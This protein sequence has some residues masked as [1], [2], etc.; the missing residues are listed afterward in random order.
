MTYQL[1]LFNTLSRQVEEFKPLSPGMV[2][3]YCCGPTVYDYQHIG[4]FKTFLIEDLLI[5]TLKLAG[6]Q[7]KFIM[8][9][10]DVGHLAS[11]ADEGED[12]MLIAARREKKKSM[13]IAQYYTDKFLEDWDKLNITRPETFCKA[14]DH[15]AEMIAMIKTLEEKG[16]AYLADGNVYFD[17]MRFK[18][19]GQLALLDL[20]KLQA[21]ARV[22]VDQNKRSPF[23][24]VLWFTKSKFENHELLWDSPWGKGYPGWHIECSAMASKYLGENID[25]HCGGVDHIPVH[26][27]NEIAQAEAAFG[28]KWVNFWVHSE[29]ILINSEKMAKSKGNFLKLDDLTAQG[30]EPAVYRTLILGTHYRKQLNFSKDSMDNA[31][32]VLQKLKAEVLKL[33]STDTPAEKLSDSAE[34]YATAFREAVFNDLNTP[35]ALAQV[36]GLLDDKDISSAEKLSLLYYFDQILGLKISDWQA[37][38]IDVPEAVKIL[39]EK[40]AAARQSKNWAESDRL[41]DEIKSLGFVVKD[42]AQGQS[43]TKLQ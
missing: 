2:K 14:T 39:L 19:Y 3:I 17:V 9:I 13:E 4:N 31:L 38:T 20:E 29:F 37:E 21:G 26:H 10:T 27:T 36:W 12:K 33:K 34:K 40:R 11:D 42:N 30:Y 23:D 43:L 25:I 7:V 28:H 1:K 8:N 18:E 6:L 15:I 32:R 16:F 24:F 5:R 41:R 35:Q 22:E